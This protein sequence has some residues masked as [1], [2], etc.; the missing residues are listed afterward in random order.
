MEEELVLP[1]GVRR[2]ISL[3]FAIKKS[4]ITSVN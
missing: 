2:W 1:K 4:K 3:G